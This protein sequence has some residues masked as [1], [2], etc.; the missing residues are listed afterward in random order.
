MKR[1]MIFVLVLG[2]VITVP[3]LKIIAAE[4]GHEKGAHTH[5]DHSKMKNPVKADAKS[6]ARGKKI[7]EE[8][9]A[10]CHG[11]SGKGDGPAGKALNPPAADF[12]DDVW[13]HGSSDGEIF[14]V[15]TEGVKNTG[16][17]SF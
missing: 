10:M 9:C 2:I 13:K 1:L 6:I 4:K 8:R 3:A 14:M 16:M 5:T 17:S 15:I 7:Y 12:T 11:V